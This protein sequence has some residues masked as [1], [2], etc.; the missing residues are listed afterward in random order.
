MRDYQ[1][2]LF[3]RG[4][5]ADTARIAELVR[6]IAAREL[7]TD[8]ELSSIVPAVFEMSGAPATNDLLRNLAAGKT[9]TWRQLG[10]LG[11]TEAEGG[12][13][14]SIFDGDPA[15]AIFL[16]E[17]KPIRPDGQP[18]DRARQ[19]SS[20]RHRFGELTWEPDPLG[21]DVSLPTAVLY[22]AREARTPRHAAQALTD[23][24]P[25]AALIEFPQAG[26]DLLRR[27]TGEVTA[28]AAA[29]ARGGLP[30]A[31]ASGDRVRHHRPRRRLLELY[32]RRLSRRAGHAP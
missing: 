18:S 23:R 10:H 30:S 7:A 9:T 27:R 24:L 19:F 12:R 15:L 5:R 11:A 6:E 16:R 20:L 8:E 14:P 29:M 26:H 13:R 32:E 17:I 1:R 22:G 21:G 4:E 28:I 31:L 25:D 2:A 3:W